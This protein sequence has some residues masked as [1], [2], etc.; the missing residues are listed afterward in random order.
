V[1]AFPVSEVTDRRHHVANG[2]IEHLVGAELLRQFAA[3]G[4]DVDGDDARLVWKSR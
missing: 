2:G 3:L 4:R 1:R